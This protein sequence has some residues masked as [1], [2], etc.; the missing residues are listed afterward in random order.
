MIDPE[1]YNLAR[2]LASLGSRSQ[3]PGNRARCMAGATHPFP[4]PCSALA[5][6]RL[7][8]GSSFGIPLRRGRHIFVE[9]WLDP[10]GT[11][12]ARVSF[13]IIN[14][15]DINRSGPVIVVVVVAVVVR[16]PR[17]SGS[18]DHQRIEQ[19]FG[20][21]HTRST[22]IDDPMMSFFISTSFLLF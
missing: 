6:D 21:F 19:G 1:L 15:A 4:S 7:A 18:K 10:A 17:W 13:E 11:G 2:S 12:L 14:D 5:K 9:I 8:R 20:Q 16:Y 22:L 3:T